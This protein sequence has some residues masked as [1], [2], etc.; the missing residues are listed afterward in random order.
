MWL[1]RKSEGDKKAQETA[2][3]YIWLLVSSCFFGAFT[4]CWCMY[5]CACVFSYARMSNITQKNEQTFTHTHTRTRTRAHT[6]THTN[7]HTHTCTDTY[8]HVHAQYSWD[9]FIQ[10]SR[11]RTKHS[12]T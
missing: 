12:V 6:S 8:I 7:T 1:A 9:V 11:E 10:K 2:R 5:V 4:M 3:T